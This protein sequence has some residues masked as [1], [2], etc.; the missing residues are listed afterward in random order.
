MTEWI[1]S[2][3]HGQ[4]V[5]AL[6]AGVVSGRV[7]DPW[8]GSSSAGTCATRIIL[9]NRPGSFGACGWRSWPS[10][11]CSSRGASTGRRAGRFFSARCFWA[12]SSSRRGSCWRRCATSGASANARRG[13]AG[14]RAGDRYSAENYSTAG[15]GL[16]DDE[17]GRPDVPQGRKRGHERRPAT[18]RRPGGLAGGISRRESRRRGGERPRTDDVAQ[19]LSEVEIAAAWSLAVLGLEGEGAQSR[20]GR[21]CW[22]NGLSRK[23]SG[24]RCMRAPI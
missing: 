14:A 19:A 24:P 20:A 16:G 17:F 7:P 4:L 8:R 13:A 11:C 23:T 15:E 10:G 1:E 5:A 22:P 12:R 3:S 21:D 2:A 6:A 18:H 9:I